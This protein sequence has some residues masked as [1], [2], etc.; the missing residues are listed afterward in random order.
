MVKLLLRYPNVPVLRTVFRCTA[1]RLD[2]IMIRQ[3][4]LNLKALA[5]RQARP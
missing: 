4:F 5:E 3:Q 2:L 1:A